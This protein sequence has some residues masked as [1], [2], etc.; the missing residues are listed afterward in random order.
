MFPVMQVY[1]ANLTKM[2]KYIYKQWHLL[3]EFQRILKH[4]TPH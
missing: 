1:S 2:G 4:H 3:L